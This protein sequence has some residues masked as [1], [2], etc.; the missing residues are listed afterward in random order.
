MASATQFQTRDRVN[1]IPPLEPGDR[2]TRQEFHRRYAA[3]P[4]LKKAELI[5]GIVHMPSPVSARYSTPHAHLMIALGTYV[6]STPGLA[7]DD[8]ATVILD[9]DN[10]VQPDIL[11]RL[12]H[13]S[14]HINDNDFFEGAPELI[15]EIAASSA[16]YDMFD[17][18]QVYRRNGVQEYLVWQVY[19]E[20]ID[21]FHLHEGRYA[22]LPADEN[23]ILRSRMFPGLHLNARALL[24]GELAAAVA[25]VQA[26]VQ[27]PEHAAFV[28]KLSSEETP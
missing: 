22:P 9:A 28:Q 20:R 6:V 19:D 17:K 23:G 24:Q 4:H 26:G 18:M 7:I 13:G 5:E 21:W 11:L 3:M 16:S 14:L 27:T 15:A 25:T 2:L 12:L 10:E 8:N 1:S